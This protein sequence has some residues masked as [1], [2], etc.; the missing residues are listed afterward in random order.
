M[1][2]EKNDKAVSSTGSV[3]PPVRRQ[4]AAVALPNKQTAVSNSVQTRTVSSQSAGKTAQ[5]SHG[6][7][8]NHTADTPRTAVSE[9]SVQ[10]TPIQHTPSSV[11]QS[12]SHSTASRTSTAQSIGV[13][14]QS[15]GMHSG[16]A[17]AGTHQSRTPQ[18]GIVH[19]TVTSYRQS[20]NS[21]SAGQS[22][23]YT[24]SANGR[25]NYQ[26]NSY[27]NSIAQKTGYSNG[28][29]NHSQTQSQLR[30][31]DYEIDSST[32]WKRPSR[33]K[34]S[35]K[36]DSYLR[37]SA[38][39]AIMS[40]VKAVIYIIFIIGVSIPLSIFVIRTANDI[41]AFQKEEKTVSITIPEYATI[42][43]VGDLLGEAG[44]IEYPWAFKLWSNLKEKSSI[45]KGYYPEFIAGTYEISTTL[46]YDYLRAAFKKKTAR[47]TTKITIPEGYTVDEIIDLFVN[48]G[49]SSREEFVDAVN[50]YDY[51]FRFVKEL[52]ANGWSSERF[53][54]L[55]GYLFPDTYEF[56]TDST[57]AQCIYK[58]LDN[59]NNKFINE[60][61]DRC[62]DLGITVDQAITLASMVEKEAR[63]ADE[64][65]NVSSVFHNRLKH[66][67]QFPYLN[68]DATIMYAIQINTGTRQETLTGSDTDY[69]SAYNTYTHR[70][71]PP[72]AIANPGLNAIKYAL[73]PNDTKYYYFVSNSYGRMLFA[74][75]EAEHLQN[76]I[77]ARES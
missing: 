30:H 68:S 17:S 76:I 77:K 6:T 4:S 26:G 57:A 8:V 25:Q 56:Y 32:T 29:G 3:A 12:A 34:F 33:K 67:S 1:M 44:V 36:E 42:E 24:N 74:E 40:A 19:S 63:Y 60:Y 39:S 54:R 48:A 50:N 35:Q 27:T 73:Y 43:D 75:T 59:F 49:I 13:H 69:D 2:E 70:G 58:L 18:T 28:Y 45:E 72:S 15:T 21:T 71:L 5:T 62:T 65:G 64:L 41:F 9:L 16:T 46:N 20:A 14:T 37:D 47:S 55:E 38:S 22:V 53:Y 66:S 61:Y 7:A 10:R 51:D 31:G 11:S 52:T 23:R